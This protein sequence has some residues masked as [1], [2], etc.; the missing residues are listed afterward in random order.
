MKSYGVT[1]DKAPAPATAAPAAAPNAALAA[2]QVAKAADGKWRCMSAGKACT[3][4]QVQALT[5]V[6]K[7]RSNVKD[8]LLVVNTDGTLTCSAAGKPC[9]EVE[10]QNAATELGKAVTKGGSQ[11][12]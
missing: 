12:Y 9:S 3:E 11:G 4:T 8:N 6:T 7:S 5:T 2:V 10:F 1:K